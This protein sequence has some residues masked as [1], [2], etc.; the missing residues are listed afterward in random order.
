MA[1]GH[2]VQD[3]PTVRDGCTSVVATHPV[4]G[5]RYLNVSEAFTRFIIG[6]AAAESGR[7][8]TQL[9]DLINRPEHH[10]RFRCDPDTIVIWDDRDKQHYAVGDYLPHRRIM[11]R[12]VVAEE[13]RART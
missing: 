2:D 7:P 4:T 12:L 8:L 9:S 1:R 13:H 10:V 5:A 6:L 3:R 11:H